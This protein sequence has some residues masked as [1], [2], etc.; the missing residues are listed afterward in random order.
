M[1]FKRSRV[2]F[3]S[4]PP[5]FH[6]NTTRVRSVPDLAKSTCPEVYSLNLKLHAMRWFGFC[7][8]IWA[9]HFFSSPVFSTRQRSRWS[10]WSSSCRTS[11]TPSMNL[12]NSS[13][14]VHWCRHDWTGNSLQ[15][16]FLPAIGRILLLSGTFNRE[17]GTNSMPSVPLCSIALLWNRT[18]LQSR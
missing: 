15:V 16:I 3:P 6:S 4:A 9:V 12:G 2:R 13:N 14:C 8:V 7:S 5:N 17:K 10:S 11:F 18:F 1:A